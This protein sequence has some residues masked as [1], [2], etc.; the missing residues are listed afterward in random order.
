MRFAT[1]GVGRAGSSEAQPD[2][3][4]RRDMPCWPGWCAALPVLMGFALPVLFMLRPLL[5]DWSL[6]PW[7]RF[8]MGRQQRASGAIT[9]VLAVGIALVLALCRASPLARAADACRGAPGQPGLRRAGR[10]HRRRPAAARWAGCSRAAPPSLSAGDH[11]RRGIVWAY[12]VR[13]CAVALQSVQS[14]YARVASLTI[15]RM[16]GVGGM[17]L[18]MRVHWLP[19]AIDGRRHVA[20]VRGRDE[21]AARNH[22]AAAL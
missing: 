15:R 10:G 11:H 21:G 18:L 16:L 1:G 3:A 5:A 8:A 22:R 20:G 13:F 9:A 14:G 6:L 2:A 19:L 4:A 7:D 17:G 12:L